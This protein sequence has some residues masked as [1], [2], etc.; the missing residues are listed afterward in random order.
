M[1][2]KVGS[3][4]GEHYHDRVRWLAD[5]GIPLIVGSDVGTPSAVF[6]TDF[7]SS[8]EAIAHVGFSLAAGKSHTGK[9]LNN[10]V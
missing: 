9:A 2:D 1:S 10:P 6:F 4:R 3:E 5:R 8:L 7:V